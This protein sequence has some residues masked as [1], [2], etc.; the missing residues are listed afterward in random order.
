MERICSTDFIRRG[1]F[2]RKDDHHSEASCFVDDVRKRR[3][4]GG[5]CGLQPS[6]ALNGLILVEACTEVL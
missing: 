1:N 2:A 3:K 6:R 4:S 5:N